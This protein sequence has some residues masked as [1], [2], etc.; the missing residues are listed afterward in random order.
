VLFIRVT[1]SFLKFLK[2]SQIDKSIQDSIQRNLLLIQSIKEAQYIAIKG[3]NF[4]EWNLIKRKY[5]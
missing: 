2:I 1:I 3:T 5:F 4:L